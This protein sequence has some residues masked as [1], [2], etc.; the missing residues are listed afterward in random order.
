M[1]IHSWSATTSLARC[2]CTISTTPFGSTSRGGVAAGEGAI[3]PAVAQP[4]S[5]RT[6]PSPSRARATALTLGDT[7][8]RIVEDVE[9][10]Q[11]GG[12]GEPPRV[13][14]IERAV[15]D[16]RHRLLRD[17]AVRSERLL[18]QRQIVLLGRLAED[19]VDVADDDQVADPIARQLEPRAAG[20]VVVDLRD[21]RGRGESRRDGGPP[22]RVVE[23]HRGERAERAVV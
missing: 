20:R 21:A 1:R 19:G 14:V 8:Q 22:R 10:S 6:T 17:A 16:E 12:A 11:V 13:G 18:E 7:V 5:S 2:S 4:A 23:I 3:A 9:V 15:D